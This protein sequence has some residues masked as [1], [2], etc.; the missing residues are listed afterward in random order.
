[1]SLRGCHLKT[2]SFIQKNRSADLKAIK[3]NVNS[4]REAQLAGEAIPRLVI[5][6]SVPA[7]VGMFVNATYTVVDRYWIGQLKDV[8]AMS[9][10]GLTTPLMMVLLGVMLLV[11]IGTTASISIR[12]GEKKHAE[13]EKILANGFTLSVIFGSVITLVGLIAL[14]PIL[15]IAGAS[16]DTLP[17]AWSYL[18]IL[19]IGVIPNTVGFA[20]N[21]TIRGA[22]N[23]RRSALTQIL[24]AALNMLLDPIFIFGLDLGVRGAAMATVISQVISAIW[25]MSYFI[26]K[27][28][29]IQ[30]KIKWMRLQWAAVKQIISIGLSPFAMQVATSLVSVLAN[31]ALRDTGGDVAIGAMTVINSVAIL[32]LMPIFGINQGLQ[33]IFGYNYGAANYARV[34]AAWIF[35]IK[36]STVIV[37]TGFLSVQLFPATIIRI[38]IDDPGL[39]E[40]GT[41]GIRVFL[42]MLPLLGFQIISTVYFQSV[43]KARVAIFASLLRQVIIL[44]P[45]YLILP[46]IY[47]LSGIWFASPIADF[48]SFVIT[49][50]L[51]SREMKKLKLMTMS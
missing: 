4:N 24:G 34:R 44:L 38:F 47:G 10:I 45:L 32:F 39:I 51:I 21:Q 36:L 13:A 19:L 41:F 11:G 33:P 49:A 26:G 28:S 30:L 29:L 8:N 6:Y 31:R 17:Y 40:I 23:P 37:M 43:G 16:K 35:G 22:G 9:G 15:V 48:C 50:V 3:M 42:S 46:G 25:V 12:L 20:M 2:S 27:D 5:R 1:M 7:V 14:R 18:R